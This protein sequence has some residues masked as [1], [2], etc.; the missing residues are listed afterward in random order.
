MLL[1]TNT[2]VSLGRLPF[3][4]RSQAPNGRLCRV[5]VTGLGAFVPGYH[6]EGSRSK[7]SRMRNGFT[8]NIIIMRSKTHKRVKFSA[9]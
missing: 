6:Y 2:S 4:D 3:I 7:S 1:G 8:H 9:F 5:A